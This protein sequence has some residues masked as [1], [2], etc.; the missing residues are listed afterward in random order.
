[1]NTLVYLGIIIST[2]VSTIIIYYIVLHWIIPK[3]E[4]FKEQDKKEDSKKDGNILLNLISKM[5]RMT[6]HL[7][8][9]STWIERIQMINMSPTELARR[10]LKSLAKSE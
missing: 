6:T 3:I 1:M 8:S 5:K 2:L 9:P 10:H 4:G 7:V